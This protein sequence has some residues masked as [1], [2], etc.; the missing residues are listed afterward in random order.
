M[1][2]VKTDSADAVN[3]VKDIVHA[4][5]GVVVEFYGVHD[6]LEIKSDDAF[7][8]GTNLN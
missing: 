8:H 7:V 4:V 1:K 6:E 3:V 5:S 2:A